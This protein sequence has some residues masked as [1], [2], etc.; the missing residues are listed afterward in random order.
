MDSDGD[1]FYVLCSFKGVKNTPTIFMYIILLNTDKL[2][3]QQQL[4]YSPFMAVGQ[5]LHEDLYDHGPSRTSSPLTP[6]ISNDQFVMCMSGQTALFLVFYLK[7]FVGIKV[8]AHQCTFQLVLTTACGLM[9]H[10][11]LLAELVPSVNVLFM[12]LWLLLSIH[13]NL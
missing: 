5:H 2:L 11:S 4:L 13:S 1:E 8:I 12:T 6:I 3:Y 9:Y 10:E 7:L